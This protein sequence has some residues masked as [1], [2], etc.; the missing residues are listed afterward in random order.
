MNKYSYITTALY[1]LQGMLV[2]YAVDLSERP[3]LFVSIILV[4]VLAGLSARLE[5]QNDIR[6][7][8][9]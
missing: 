9:Q 6:R 2:G 8:Q 4:A 5:G 7:N 1:F 3:W